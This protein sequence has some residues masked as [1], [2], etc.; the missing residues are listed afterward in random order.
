MTATVLGVSRIAGETAPLLMTAF[1]SDSVNTNPLNGPQSSLPLFAFQ[2]VRA[3]LPTQIARGWA[4]ALVLI[5]LVLCLFT[6]AR[7]VAARGRKGLLMTEIPSS[8]RPHR[9]RRPARP[10][11]S[12]PS[13]AGERWWPTA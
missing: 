5:V 1:G 4:G 11:R 9:H 2:R 8:R 12:R 7:A 6:L 13:P 3:A 10:A